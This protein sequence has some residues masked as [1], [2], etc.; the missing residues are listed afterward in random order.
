M[1][2]HIVMWKFKDSAGGKS[3]Q[4]NLAKAKS[5]LD[6]LPSRINEIKLFDVG[7]D[8]V[9]SK[10]SY[11]LVLRSGFADLA[12]LEAYQSHPEHM[13]VVEFL[14]GVQE[15]RVVVDYEAP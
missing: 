15:S 12:A 13:K 6:T 1:L 2:Y 9:H 10:A 3:K 8:I 14:R 5:L 7:V 4:E 11:D